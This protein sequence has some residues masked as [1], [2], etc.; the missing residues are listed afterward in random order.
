MVD[1]VSESI[2]VKT[3]SVMLVDTS[4]WLYHRF[5]ALRNWYHRAYP[6]KV[7]EPDFNNATYD[8][9]NDEIFITKYKK[10]FIANLKKICKKY[11]I[12]MKNVVFC[13]DCSHKDIW[14]LNYNNEY[15]GT[16]LES[17]K[18]N[19]FNSFNIFNYIKKDFLIKEQIT[20]G[21]KILHHEKSEA[22]DIIGLFAPYLIKKGFGKVYILASDNDYLQI[23]NDNITLLDGNGKILNKR[24]KQGEKYLISKILMGDI[25]DNIKCCQINCGFLD[26]GFIGTNYKNIY[27]SLIEKILCSSDKYEII[28]QILNYNRGIEILSSRELCLDVIK[29]FK[30]NQILIDFEMIPIQIKQELETLFIKLI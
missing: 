25:S 2:L 9:F 12:T 22:D 21:F 3:E 15:K 14:R 26:N 11:K 16:R 17:H 13:I 24:D 5:F 28:R 6:N 29:N 19:E 10:L 8:W 7:K 23:C 4:Y 1:N 20:N 27:K 18:K 30:E